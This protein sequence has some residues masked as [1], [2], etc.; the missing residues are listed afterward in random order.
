MRYRTKPGVILTQ[1]CGKYFLIA[2]DKNIQ[3][4]SSAALCWKMLINGSEVEELYEV[5]EQSYDADRNIIR[6]DVDILIEKLC[7]NDLLV[8]ESCE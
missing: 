7:N 3:I 8:G 2:P 4:S 5:M 1:V 6:S